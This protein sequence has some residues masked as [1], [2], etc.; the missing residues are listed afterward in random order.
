[1]LKHHYKSWQDLNKR[2]EERLCEPLRGRISYFLTRYHKVHDSYGRASIRLDGKELVCFSWTE[3]I[4]QDNET[5]EIW[6]ETGVWD[7]DDPALKEKWN[8]EGTFSD[9]DFLEAATDYLETGIG[10]A[11]M[12]DNPLVRIF[13]V[14]D[15]RVGKRTLE[16]IKSSGEYKSLPEWERQFW[17]LRLRE[18]KI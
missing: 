9:W 15:R 1:M 18:E 11:L 6:K 16:K 17:E 12:S 4:R 13:A 14:L 2:L 3:M 10:D 7:Y 8:R 5:N